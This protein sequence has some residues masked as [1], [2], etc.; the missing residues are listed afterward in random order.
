MVGEGRDEGAC[1]PR[2]SEVAG[3]L[4]LGALEGGAGFPDGEL[5]FDV[6]SARLTVRA[7]EI[8]FQVL[9]PDAVFLHQPFDPRE[10]LGVVVA[11]FGHPRI[12]AEPA[13]RGDTFFTDVTLP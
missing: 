4:T 9:V 7:R 8:G 6:S 13:S 12:V 5:R 10:A 2:V 11:P 3:A 1:I